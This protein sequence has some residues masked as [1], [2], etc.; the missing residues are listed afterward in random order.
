MPSYGPESPPHEWELGEDG[1]A[2]AR[3]LAAVLPRDARL[4]A[5]SEPKAFQTLAPMG[6]MPTDPR[7]DE[8]ARVE[9]W[10]G[11]YRRLRHEYVSGFDH[12]GWEPRAAVAVR[13]EAAV[14]E[15][16]D[17][18]QGRPLIIATHGMAMTVW[19]TSRRMLADPAEFWAQLR[20]PDAHIVDLHPRR[21][22]VVRHPGL[23]TLRF[24]GAR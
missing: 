10:E 19:L 18:A 15:H 22:A 13:F 3:R 24:D 20:F 17:A 6:Q 11:E 5:S 2:A 23:A 8:V 21:A 1:R 4:V 14:R 16:L 7:F 9:P 12:A